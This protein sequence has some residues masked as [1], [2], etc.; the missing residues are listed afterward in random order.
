MELTQRHVR[1]VK[2]PVQPIPLFEELITLLMEPGNHHVTLNIDCKMQNDPETMFVS[3]CLRVVDAYPSSPRWL[4][5]SL[6]MITGKRSLPH[7]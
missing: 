2:E 1:T 5:S 4:E 7:A 3:S 6:R